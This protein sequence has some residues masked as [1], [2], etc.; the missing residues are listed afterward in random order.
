MDMS[1]SKLWELVMDREAWHAAV[2]GVGKNQTEL[3]DWTEL[4]MGE[5]QCKW[6]GPLSHLLRIP[7]SSPGQLGRGTWAFEWQITSD[8]KAIGP[9]AAFPLSKGM[10]FIKDKWCAFSSW[11]RVPPTQWLEDAVGGSWECQWTGFQKDALKPSSEVS[12]RA[13]TLANQSLAW[14]PWRQTG[15]SCA[16]RGNSSFADIQDW[17]SPGGGGARHRPFSPRYRGSCLPPNVRDSQDLVSCQGHKG[18]RGSSGASSLDF[19]LPGQRPPAA[20]FSFWSKQIFRSSWAPGGFPSSRLGGDK[21]LEVNPRVLATGGQFGPVLCR[22]SPEN[23]AGALTSHCLGRELE[24]E[25]RDN[26]VNDGV[27]CSRIWCYTDIINL[28]LQA[29]S[30]LAWLLWVISGDWRWERRGLESRLP[31]S[32]FAA[33]LPEGCGSASRV[34]PLW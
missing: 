16:G 30:S 28:W 17:D 23:L 32:P 19:L 9:K 20:L 22:V 3:S 33:E 14:L 15:S 6:P 12:S 34:P 18:R 13:W 27:Y 5:P 31:E 29:L 25:P 2:H 8:Y 7:T 21:S 24:A 4:R 11:P 1:L 10:R 26:A